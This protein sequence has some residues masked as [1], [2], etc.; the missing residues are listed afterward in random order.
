MIP[1]NHPQA[2]VAEAGEEEAGDTP[3]SLVPAPEPSDKERFADFELP[4]PALLE[5]PQPF[6]M[7]TK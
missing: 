5:D 7:T 3:L 2:A 4:P 1:I 6:P